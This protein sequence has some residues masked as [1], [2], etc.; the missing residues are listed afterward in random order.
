M[1]T[2]TGHH[3]AQFGG[4]VEDDYLLRGQG[5]FLDDVAL[6]GQAYAVFVRSPHAFA[7]IRKID[8]QDA[9][10]GK[11]V[12]AVL[13]AADMQAAGVGNITQHPPMT[14]R[15]GAKVVIPPRLPLAAERVMHVGEPVAMV[16]ADTLLAAQ[17]AAELVAVDYEELTP[18]TDLRAAIRPDA[19]Q[20]WPEAP[21][22]IVVDWPGRRP[23]RP[24]TR[25]R[26]TASS[27]RRAR[28]ARVGGQ[29]ARR[30]CDDGAARRHRALRRGQR[31]FRTARLLAERRRDAGQRPGRDGPDKER[32][33]VIT[34]EVGG[35]FGMKTG[36]LSGISGAAGGARR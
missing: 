30:S 33:R 22:N 26:S 13:T 9:R 16:V 5:H 19:P 23:T 8:T 10:A 21:G 15:G 7:R 17:D 18:V 2:K 35:A 11:G 4:R 12:L 29:P 24:P 36:G 6:P 25:R 32:L 1:D 27:N 3:H 31:P 14:G 20:L 34:E 28:G